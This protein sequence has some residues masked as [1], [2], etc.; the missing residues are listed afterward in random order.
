[1]GI[2]QNVSK[3]LSYEG[4]ECVVTNVLN[5]LQ[6][7]ADLINGN[8][9]VKGTQTEST[10]KWTGSLPEYMNE[11]K[12]GLTINYF[13]PFESN[14]QAATLNLSNKG[15]KPI[16]KINGKEIKNDFA[17]KTIIHIM[18]IVDEELNNGN[19]CWIVTGTE[20]EIKIFKDEEGT[21]PVLANKTVI[22]QGTSDSNAFHGEIAS[23]VTI[24]PSSGTI[25]ANI[26]RTK[27]GIEFY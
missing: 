9:Y 8:F 13:L 14:D 1:M 17:A 22:D 3:F 16:Y 11:Y 10:N 6:K 4:L 12:E 19:G 21:F 20:T 2:G 15:E 25:S 23:D 27:S 5:L 18:Y 7:K 24:T 26:F